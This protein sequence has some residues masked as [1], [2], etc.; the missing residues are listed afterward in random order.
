MRLLSARLRSVRPLS[1]VRAALVRVT[2]VA[3]L[4]VA[5]WQLARPPALASAPPVRERL[6]LADVT[7][8]TGDAA[9]GDVVAQ[10]LRHELARSPRLEVVGR[11]RIDAA[12]KRMRR[13]PD[14]PLSLEV[15]RE[16]AARE[17]VKIVV[18]G[19]ARP[20]G[21]GI[22]VSAAVIDAASGDVI[23]GASE[24]AR[25]STEF[26][27]TVRRLSDGIREGIGESLAS[28][29][30]T[31]P[32]WSFTTASLAALRKQQGEIEAWARGDNLRGVELS[33]EALALDPAFGHA[34]VA[35]A[36]ELEWAGLPRGR[37]VPGLVRAYQSR[38]RL[39]DR[40][41]YAIEGHYH[42]SVTGD[43][44][45][46]MHAFR[47]MVETR[48]CLDW[49][50][51]WHTVVG[52]TLEL[53]GDHA[54]AER[55]LGHPRMFGSAP[56]QVVR[57]RALYALGRHTEA[58]QL[59][60][61]LS[62]RDPEHPSVL[63]LQVAL[64]ADSGRL[65]EAH[66]LASRIRRSSGLRNDLYTQAALDAMRGRFAEAVAHL[67]ELRDQA[68][69]L[70]EPAA[71]VG[72]AVAAGRLRLRA[73]DS[74]GASEVD[75]RLL[76]QLDSADVLSRPYLPLALLAAEAGQVRQARAWL[77]TYERQV[78]PG[79]R[80]PDRPSWH[81]A[82]AAVLQAEGRLAPALQE[83]QEAAR[84]PPARTG[85]F[86]VWAVRAE[87]RPELARL[88]EAMG[89]SDSAIAVY[90][91]YLA[92]PSLDRVAIDAFELGAAHEH[93]SMLYARCGEWSRAA[94]HTRRFV[95]LWRDSDAVPR[96]RVSAA[97]RRAT[98]IAEKLVSEHAGH[99]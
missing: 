83:L 2:A 50:P 71:A 46:A 47:N 48:A 99:R 35:L 39:T 90:E 92:A 31:K 25:D 79:L 12:L 6:L 41:R 3:S 88:Y 89:A 67:R 44:A 97:H 34:R 62:Q 17:E 8:Q 98:S 53:S 27:A 5:A 61:A 9:L 91:R 55:H 22:V 74:A 63:R 16:V 1:A 54:A 45:Q 66:A 52:A 38:H 82:R 69:A 87:D 60:D 18:T 42:L 86:E 29:G 40:E 77:V 59:L 56:V 72:I 51:C 81:H 7:N 73:G 58:R 15:A 78:P 93:L 23:H 96:R 43:L 80:G 84:L 24:T 13:A 19:D 70:G 28:I 4:A 11:A 14:A 65:D 10:V 32:L 21:R 37:A 75:D 57:V 68:L 95:E 64:L 36:S 85:L 94:A 49:E 76:R 20:V 33:E 30:A 26:V